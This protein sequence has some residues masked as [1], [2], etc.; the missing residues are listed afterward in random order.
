MPADKTE[1]PL[2]IVVDDPVPDVALAVQNGRSGA[3]TLIPPVRK[4]ANAVVFDVAIAA[5]RADDGGVRL[6][7]AIVQGPPAAR[8]LYICVGQAA[9][10]AGSPWTRR[11]KVPLGGITSAMVERLK[12]GQR[13]T[14]HIHGRD[15]KGDP[16]CASVKLT[17]AWKAA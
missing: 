7:G 2:R 6:L 15:K 16:A 8:F 9:G 14:A 5:S 13:L 10:Q 17:E 4:A 11:I 3:A 1:L 12:S